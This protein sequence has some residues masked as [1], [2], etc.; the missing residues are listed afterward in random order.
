V[1]LATIAS[2]LPNRENGDDV[3]LEDHKKTGL[4]SATSRRDRQQEH[5][6]LQEDSAQRTVAWSAEQFCSAV[7]R[8]NSEDDADGE[9]DPSFTILDARDRTPVH[10]PTSLLPEQQSVQRGGGRMVGFPRFHVEANI[11]PDR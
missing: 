5:K 10:P 1:H 8:L 9:D 6:L 7:R 11:K 3:I 2:L 4:T